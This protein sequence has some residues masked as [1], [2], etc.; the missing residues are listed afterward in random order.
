MK[1]NENTAHLWAGI[2][3]ALFLLVWLCVF[4][5]RY[6]MN[7]DIAIESVLSGQY[8]GIPD[9]HAIYVKYP[10]G[11]MI[12]CFYRFIPTV[13]WYK[14]IMLIICWFAMAVV[15][16]GLLNRYKKNTMMHC[17]LYFAGISLLWAQCFTVFTFSTCGAFV[18]ASAVIAYAMLSDED[19]RKIKMI[20]PILLLFWLAYCIRDYFALAGL[21]LLGIIWLAKH[22]KH[23]W[24][25]KRCFMIPCAGFLGLAACVLINTYAYRSDDWQ[26]Y[27]SYNKDLTVIQDYLGLPDYDKNKEFYE[28]IDLQKWELTPIKQFSYIFLDKYTPERLHDVAEYA[29]S[30]Q[31]KT[32]LT[33][34]VKKTGKVFFFDGK[35]QVLM[36]GTAFLSLLVIVL[37]IVSFIKGRAWESICSLLL[38]AG[39]ACMWL[40]IVYKGRYP[41]RVLQSLYILQAAAGAAGI[42]LLLRDVKERT[43]KKNVHMVICIACAAVIVISAVSQI[44]TLA[45]KKSSVNAGV[46]V[47]A[48]A[49]PENI[50]FKDTKGVK[51]TNV[52]EHNIVATASW[53]NYS[54]LYQHR[55]ENLGMKEIKRSTL[56]EDGK[57][58][59]TK[60]DKNM[61]KMLGMAPDS[62]IE[63]EIVDQISKDVV[64]V[65][66]TKIQE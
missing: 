35:N 41:E 56:L 14:V 28:S 9:G 52:V 33:S 22:V 26:A 55:I 32:T 15:V 64:V 39:M 51:T 25:D 49:H 1:R 57:Y 20:L 47:Y 6:A 63:Y 29:Q 54:P 10:L 61:H 58:L 23:C 40:Y 30:I 65:R 31:K 59:I 7:D 11:W 36:I 45:K 27:F 24:K 19:E 4:P 16:Y 50:Y 34:V 46:N 43:K 62:Q 5:F 13:N 60:P 44:P 21:L 2:V 48:A 18:A 37:A 17:L 53:L 12:S 42:V 38:Q 8:T 3:S 66:F